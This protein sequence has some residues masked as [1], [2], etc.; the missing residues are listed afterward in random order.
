MESRI[1]LQKLLV[2]ANKLPQASTFYTFKEKGGKEMTE[3]L[4]QGRFSD[5]YLNIYVAM[6][7]FIFLKKLT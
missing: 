4:K 7:E 3:S 6:Q 1:K 5:L 2:I